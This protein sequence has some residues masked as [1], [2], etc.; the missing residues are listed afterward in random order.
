[1]SVLMVDTI[2]KDARNQS[3]INLGLEIVRK[4]LGADY[5]TWDERLIRGYDTIAFNIFYPTH[6]FN[7]GAFLINNNIEPLKHRRK[8][9]RIIVGGQGIGTKHILSEIADEEFNG[10]FDY[11]ENKK[12]IVTGEIIK[13]N[14]AVIE[15]TRGCKYRC[16]FCEYAYVHGGRY[17][18]KNIELVKEQVLNLKKKGM[19]NINFLSANFAGYSGIDDLLEFCAYN[20]IRVLNSDSCLNDV[21]KLIPHKRCLMSFIKIGVESFNEAT[22]FKVGKRTTDNEL[23]NILVLLSKNF[24]YIH[25]YLIYG[26]PDDNYN[27]WFRWL[28]VLAEIRRE[29]SI[30][31]IDLFGDKYVVHE[32]PIRYAFNITNFEPCFNTPLQDAGEVDFSSK[33]KFLKQWT[34]GLKKHGFH[35]GDD[36]TYKNS[37]GRFGRK[38]N[39]YRLL[40]SLKNGGP[41][42][43]DRL[44]YTFKNGVSR[45]ISDDEANLFLNNWAKW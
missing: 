7:V 25:S 32:K 5:C 22:R 23:Y 15:L 42:L 2:P 21:E 11:K 39:S 45:S 19:R 24:Y 28:N 9:C 16:S 27:E 40:M 29:Y 1:M 35:F 13:G 33:D 31:N 3:S 6:L 14:K 34:A 41:E 44:L 38:E 12:E 30:D 37:G 17:R 26:L 8:G 4:G 43:T 20:Y 10:E 18:E 36:I